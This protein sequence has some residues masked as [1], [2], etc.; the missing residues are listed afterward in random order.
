[1]SLNSTTELENE[2]F[3]AV[4][5]LMQTSYPEMAEQ[6]GIWRVHNHFEIDEDEIFHETSNAETKESTL[7]SFQKN[8][9]A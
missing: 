2:F 1:M 6:F 4:F 9:L 3:S 5:A 8:R 7:R